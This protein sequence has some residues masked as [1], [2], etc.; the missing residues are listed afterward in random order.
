MVTL[1]LLISPSVLNNPAAI[2]PHNPEKILMVR[3]LN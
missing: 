3:E 2:K 1:P